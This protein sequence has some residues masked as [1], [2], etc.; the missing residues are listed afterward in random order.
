M[1][2][3]K[4][5][6]IFSLLT[7]KLAIAQQ[8][9]A[10]ATLTTDLSCITGYATIT[11]VASGGTPDYEYKLENNGIGGAYQSSNVFVNLIAGTYV[12]KVRDRNGNMTNSN[13]VTIASVNAPILNVNV[14][15]VTCYGGSNGTITG[16]VTGGKAPYLYSIL[17]PIAISQQPSNVFTNLPAGT[18]T[19]Q[20]T[21]ALGCVSLMTAA[22]LQPVPLLSTF[23]LSSNGT[24]TISATG[25]VPSYQYSI[26]GGANFVSSNVFS[27]L[28]PATYPIVVKDANDCLVA[29]TVVLQP[30]TPIINNPD[31]VFSQGA[32]LAD[33]VVQGQNIKWYAT[34]SGNKMA[35]SELSLSTVLVDGTTY[36]V[37]QT[38]NGIES[39]KAPI[40]VKVGTL[41]NDDFSFQNLKVYPIPA[42]EILTV[43]NTSI[44]NKVAVF[45]YLGAEVLSESVDKSNFEI[46]LSKF[47]KGVYFVRVES[48][49]S[50]KII[51]FIKE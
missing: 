19:I 6:L 8:F 5:L 46:N 25:G 48:Q 28:Q 3:K 41:S 35:S 37:S 50:Q 14:T 9:S 36:Y 31:Q 10:V 33:I 15:N 18:Y 44:I 34:Q 13:S 47:A 23:N 22:I 24:L 49:D 16:I 12:V 30:E 45:N 29:S 51:K 7:T 40:T 38:V 27:G 20:V 2:L 26:D 32:T 4:L 42:K 11:V 17:H 39:Q 21:D 43:A 1:T